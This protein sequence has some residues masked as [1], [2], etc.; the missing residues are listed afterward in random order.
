M[1][2]VATYG[3]CCIGQY[4]MLWLLR[5]FPGAAKA[6]AMGKLLLN[7]ASMPSFLLIKFP[8]WKT[9]TEVKNGLTICCYM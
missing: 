7:V 9:R 8:K 1:N 2:L 3:V 4:M 6:L 5:E